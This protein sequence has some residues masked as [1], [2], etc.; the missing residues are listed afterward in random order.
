MWPARHQGQRR[1]AGKGMCSSECSKPFL[2]GLVAFTR[3]VNRAAS[4]APATYADLT[5]TQLGFS[6]D[7]GGWARATQ[8][9]KQG[10]SSIVLS[11]VLLERRKPHPLR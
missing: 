6:T 5:H 10:Q 11:T 8:G 4:N 2:L 7:K 9:V 1:Y 3:F